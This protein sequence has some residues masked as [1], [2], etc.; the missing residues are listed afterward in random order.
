MGSLHDHIYLNLRN[1]G[2]TTVKFGL[3]MVGQ[4]TAQTLTWKTF[5]VAKRG[6]LS[7][8]MT[9]EGILRNTGAM[10]IRKIKGL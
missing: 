4:A 9:P 2:T 1:Y 10:N 6:K 3:R 5:Q 8:G 7:L